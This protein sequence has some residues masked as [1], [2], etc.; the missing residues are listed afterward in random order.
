MYLS[1]AQLMWI[2]APYLNAK[3]DLVIPIGSFFHSFGVTKHSSGLTALLFTSSI[4]EEVSLNDT[5]RAASRM[6]PAARL[7]YFLLDLIS[8]LQIT[9]R[10]TANRFARRKATSRL[11]RLLCR[12]WRLM[13]SCWSTLFWT[14]SSADPDSWTGKKRL[15]RS[16]WRPRRPLCKTLCVKVSWRF[17]FF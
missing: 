11:H 17:S 14:F 16:L 13:V 9:N 6:R 10:T 3:Y 7:V 4:R 15:S 8:R 5:L 2:K 1:N 12:Y